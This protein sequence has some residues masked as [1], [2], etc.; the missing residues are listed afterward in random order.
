MGLIVLKRMHCFIKILL[1]RTP[2]HNHSVPSRS[3]FNH[4]A[5]DQSISERGRLSKIFSSPAR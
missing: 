5:S 2:D 3:R 4:T 1:F